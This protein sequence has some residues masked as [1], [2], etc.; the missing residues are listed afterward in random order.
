M[1]PAA[2]PLSQRPFGSGFPSSWRSPSGTPCIS[3]SASP[4]APRSSSRTSG[5]SMA[6]SMRFSRLG[7]WDGETVYA[8]TALASTG[9]MEIFLKRYGSRK[10]LFGSDFPFGIPSSELSK[11]RHLGLK[12]ADF[13]NVVCANVLRLIRQD[14]RQLRPGRYRR[15]CRDLTGPCVPSS[16]STSTASRSD[17]LHDPLTLSTGCGHLAFGHFLNSLGNHERKEMQHENS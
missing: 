3:S 8:D 16:R 14:S 1:T 5:A 12:D 13:E 7:V 17:N 6:D 10:L 2:R 15:E 4:G 9:E 11:V